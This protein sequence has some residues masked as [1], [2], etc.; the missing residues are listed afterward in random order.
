[1]PILYEI[2]SNLQIIQVYKMNLHVCVQ[3]KILPN[4]MGSPNIE[5]QIGC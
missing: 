4:L 1:M 3:T 2:V 5:I